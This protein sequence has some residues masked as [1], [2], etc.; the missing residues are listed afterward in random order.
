MNQVNSTEEYSVSVV[1]PAF[2]AGACLGRAIE[3]VLA[4]RY[5][6]KEIIVVND[7]STDDTEEVAQGFGSK[8]KYIYQASGGVSVARNKGIEASTGRWVAFLDADDEFGPEKLE[9]QIELLRRNPDLRWCV[10]NYDRAFEGR[11][12]PTFD[13][14][15]LKKGLAGKDYFENY[16]R[17]AVRWKFR[18]N[19]PTIIIR[20]DIF[21][22]LG[23]FEPGRLRG[24]DLDVWWRIAHRYPKIGMVPESHGV[25][26]LDI[27][28][29]VLTKRRLES[30]RGQNAREIVARHL[31]LAKES[32][33]LEDFKSYALM[34]MRGILLMTLFHGFKEDARMIVR[35]FR[36]LFGWHWQVVTYLLT[37][38]PKL[39]SL[40]AKYVVRSAEL[41]G[42]HKEV[43]RRGKYATVPS[44]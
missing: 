5:P 36:I 6:A 3:S 35:E 12:H 23:V 15:R 16:F 13:E 14:G 18:A 11:Q 33:T 39:T 30:K 34:H 17:D 20:K 7:G 19:T 29:P 43:T 26:H 10:A 4:Q 25:V 41:V 32:N 8:I 37:V 2:N 44:E 24:Q 28:D 9:K 31:E 42:L 38:C 22:E 1:I 40:V 27:Q 21:D